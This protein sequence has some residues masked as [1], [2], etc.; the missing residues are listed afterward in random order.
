M[1]GKHR[2][3]SVHHPS[4]HRPQ[5]ALEERKKQA[6]RELWTALAVVAFIIVAFVV[7]HYLTVVKPSEPMLISIATATPGS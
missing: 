3:S 6:Q 5:L 7:F 1:A 2:V 4:V